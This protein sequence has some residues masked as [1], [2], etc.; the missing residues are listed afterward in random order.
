MSKGYRYEVSHPGEDGLMPYTEEVTITLLSGDPGGEAG[1]FEQ[2]M[3]H[4]LR[5]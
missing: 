4:A 2:H 3:Q 5:D 1:E